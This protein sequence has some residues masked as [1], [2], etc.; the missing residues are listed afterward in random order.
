MHNFQSDR[1]LLESVDTTGHGSAIVNPPNPTSQQNVPMPNVQ[2]KIQIDHFV[3]IPTTVLHEPD[4]PLN[5]VQIL[6][7]DND[8]I[9][10]G[11][12]KSS[13]AGLTSGLG[14]LKLISS[15]I[16]GQTFQIVG[17][18]DTLPTAETNELTSLNFVDY[19]ALSQLQPV[20]VMTNTTDSAVYLLSLKVD[21]E[22]IPEEP[23]NDNKLESQQIQ[24]NDDIDIK[25]LREPQ[26]A[27]T[28][29][30]HLDG[31]ATMDKTILGGNLPQS[32][33]NHLK[34]HVVSNITPINEVEEPDAAVEQHKPE[35][36]PESEV[37]HP[38]DVPQEVILNS[39][40]EVSDYKTDENFTEEFVKENAK[41]NCQLKTKASRKLFIKEGNKE[42]DDKVE[43]VMM[44]N[45][46]GKIHNETYCRDWLEC[47]NNNN[48]SQQDVQSDLK[49]NA[50]KCETENDISNETSF[51]GISSVSHSLP[52]VPHKKKITSVHF[53]KSKTKF[54]NHN[55]VS[56][57]LPLKV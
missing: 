18:T 33:D 49:S 31:I 16:S 32:S 54:T 9:I 23:K 29:S 12:P 39:V 57:P 50:S 28:P 40:E 10:L 35:C 3:Q 21:D 19:N 36:L 34:K 47:N 42:I 14:N 45:D 20:Q 15:G 11:S 30:G 24:G 56:S 41:K 17:S 52:V 2:E 51:T 55:N 43:N 38:E 8:P 44:M 26:H 53:G 6:G 37:T 48:V 27:S 22:N 4:L 13:T 1:K 46:D 7:A 5:N 25:K